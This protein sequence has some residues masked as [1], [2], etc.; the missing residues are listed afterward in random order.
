MIDDLRPALSTGKANDILARL[1]DTRPEQAL[2]AEM[3]LGLLWGIRQVADMD[4]EPAMPGSSKR[5]EAFSAGLF[6]TPA[7][8]EIT[9][10]SDGK[11]SGEADMR[12]AAKKIAGFA[13]TVKRGCGKYLFFTFREIR[14]WEANR[15]T[16]KHGVTSEFALGEQLKAD[17][18]S[19]INASSRSHRQPFLLKNEH[20]DVVVEFRSEPQ[21]Q[22]FNFFSS[23]PPLGLRLRE[24]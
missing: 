3:E 20:I 8:I 22:G 12:R 2:G 15:Y 5:P 21:R 7:Y 19:W 18:T 9:T 23:L 1:S 14:Y 16:R 6:G 10:L 13:N 11:L 4:V 24:K 17:L